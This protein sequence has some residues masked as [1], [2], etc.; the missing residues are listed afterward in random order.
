MIEMARRATAGRRRQRVAL[1]LARSGPLGRSVALLMGP[2]RQIAPVVLPLV[3]RWAT[4]LLGLGILLFGGG[5]ERTRAL[6]PLL[7]AISLG[8]LLLGSFALSRLFGSGWPRRRDAVALLGAADL[9]LALLLLWLEGGWTT[10]FYEYA[11]TTVVLPSLVFGVTG[12]VVTSAAFTIGFLTVLVTSSVAPSDSSLSSQI[13]ALANPWI[14]GG[15]VALLA[16][17][18]RRLERATA[19]NLELAMREERWR[20]AREIHDGV[21]QQSY[22]LA[23]G[24][25]TAAELARRGDLDG[26]R[27]QLPPLEKL[28]RQA[29]LEVRQYVAEAR[30]LVLGERTLAAA[31]AGLAREYATV[32]GIDIEVALPEREPHLPPSRESALYRIA[33]ESL[34]NVF[35][36]AEAQ[37][38]WLSL[39]VEPDRV[40]L[41]VA[42][43]GRGL[44]P[45]RANGGFGLEGM[46]RRVAEH[47]GTFEVGPRLSGGTCVRAILPTEPKP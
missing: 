23:L 20:I 33:Q 47:G 13:A 5:S 38:A 28:A 15:F 37:H 21:A 11:M 10:V 44:A 2:R 40:V 27:R 34:S 41:E 14:V 18:L 7:L 30:P 17:L 36:H 4:W 12:A 9:A 46:R 1:A 42:D 43:D 3:A 29:L 35:K 8:T 19:R 26:L 31:L 39:R 32:T 45:Q 6:W 22:A 16:H 24:L 25:E